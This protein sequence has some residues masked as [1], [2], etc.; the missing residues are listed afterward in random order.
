MLAGCA[1]ARAEAALGCTARRT[2]AASAVGTTAAV[3]ALSLAMTLAMRAIRTLFRAGRLGQLGLLSQKIL[4]QR[5]DRRPHAGELF[6]PAQVSA[7]VI[8]HEGDGEAGRAG[9]RGAADAV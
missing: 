4:R 2:L 7:F 3:A 9:A 8:G 6:D 5:H 1:F